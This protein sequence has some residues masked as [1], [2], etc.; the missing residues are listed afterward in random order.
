MNSRFSALITLTI[1]ALTLGSTPANAAPATIDAKLIAA[2]KAEGTLTL[3]GSMTTPQLNKLAKRFTAAYG[4]KV[5]TLRMESNALPSRMMIEAHAGS[6]R[7]DV[8]DEPGFQI[9]LLKRQGMLERFAAPENAEM[10][11][12][13][14]DRDGYWSSLFL[15]TETIGY[16]PKSL[17]AAG[18]KAPTSW[19]D[20][21]KPEWRGKFA[22]FNGS[23][24][25]YAAMQAAFGKTQ[26]EALVRAIAAN[27]PKMVN[28]HQLAENMLEAGEYVAAI[29]TYGYNMARDQRAGL[30][31]ANVN[32]DP[33][34]VEIHG[35]GV[36]AHGPH[37]NAAQLF[38]RWSLGEDTQQWIASSLGRISARKD[39]KNDP[40]IF[41][42]NI[43]FVISDPAES[44]HYT[45]YQK[46][47]NTIFNGAG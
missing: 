30:N 20:F 4:I 11:S 44:V 43:K 12:G 17:E 27:A 1:L 18:L 45:D 29:N 14:F 42:S 19:Q 9:D 10:T 5:E 40:A 24:E 3:Y 13:T 6:P 47:F 25:W 28:S 36:V 23:Y 15:N 33:T 34:I 7:A 41:G 2:A 8:V 32:P 16:N 22:V 26:G 39:V 37:P 35:I 21:T 31:A 46:A 38:L